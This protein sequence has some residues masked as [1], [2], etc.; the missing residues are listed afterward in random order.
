MSVTMEGK[1]ATFAGINT[2]YYEE[3]Q[4]VPVLFIH[5][6]G[7]GVSAWA[8][9]RLVLPY[10]SK[11]F[12]VIAPDLAGFGSTEKLDEEN[13]GMDV[14]VNQLSAMIENKGLERV[15]IVGNSLGGAIALHLAK[16][17][18]EWIHK[19]VLMGT[20]GVPFKLT[21]GLDK[22]WG[23]TPSYENMAEL[24]DIF[25]YDDKYANDSDLI[26]LRYKQTL[27]KENQ[28]AFE[29]M[30]PAPRQVHV[31]KLALSEEELREIKHPVLALHGREDQVIP[32]ENSWKVFQSVTNVEIHLFSKCGHWIQIE[33]TDEFC[34]Q[35]KLFLD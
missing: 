25:S 30:F 6:S 32:V 12:H 20:V 5:G 24:I 35:V 2:H 16:R 18:P 9:W 10:F 14:W 17:K 3:G 22:V 7:P 19:I 34:K 15:S 1:R 29:S 8:N 28:E 11:H 4:G 31:N 13:Y 21:E 23:Y 33:K 26:E 27:E